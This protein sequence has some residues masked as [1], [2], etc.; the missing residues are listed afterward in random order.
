[1]R[2]CLVLGSGRSGTSMVAGILAKSGYNTGD[3]FVAPRDTNPSGFFEDSTVAAVND[4]ILRT[5]VKPPPAWGAIG[6]I[7]VARAVLRP[8]VVRMPDRMLDAGLWLATPSRTPSLPDGADATI[9]EM[10][11][12][13][14][15]AYKDPRFCN[16]LPAWRPLLPAGT[17]RIVIFREPQRTANSIVKEMR[18][19]P[20]YRH[21][22]VDYPRAIAIW[23]ALY[24][25]LLEHRNDGGAWVFVH[26][27]QVLSGEAIP[28]LERALG[29]VLDASHR[30]PAL[31]RSGASGASTNEA[32]RV[33]AQLLALSQ[34]A[35]R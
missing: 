35:E 29:V 21:V 30:D 22:P 26:Y 17:V 4:R 6:R 27:D 14:P 3:N 20:W 23:T 18:T 24:T 5:V 2:N 1:M 12:R 28:R 9:R 15:F 25:K 7:P 16:T 11:A 34:P 19:K 31:K 13:Q 8:W 32:D 33:Y 10:V